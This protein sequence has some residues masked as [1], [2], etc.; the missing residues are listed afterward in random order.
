M[1]SIQRLIPLYVR[2]IFLGNRFYSNSKDLTEE[3]NRML[4][5]RLMNTKYSEKNIESNSFIK[6]ITPHYKFGP[7]RIMNYDWT[8]KSM[9]S[10][11][12]HKSVEFHKINQGYIADRVKILGSDLGAAHFVIYRGGAIR[13][14]GQEDFIRWTNK[15]EEYHTN[16]PET[17]DPN[18]FVEAIDVSD[19][20]LYYE[21]I[22]NFKNLYKLKWLSLR[23][24]PV[25]D[26]WC[27]DYI[28][29][30]IPNLEYLDIS[31][32]P[33]ITGAGIA[34]LQKLTKLKVLIVNSNNIE[35]Q[36]ACFALEDSIPGLFVSI[37][38]NETKLL[39]KEEKLNVNEIQ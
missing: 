17:Y 6:F 12:K 1:N 13:F 20:M 38:N 30:A 39:T 36:M 7:S 5:E 26:N 25:L 21:G 15:K 24:N 10:W 23:N 18:Y 19:L 32:C 4:Y 27:L 37:E 2:R 31:R 3:E 34:G 11:Y 9:F 35:V 28:S 29:Y 8:V 16:L 22:E 14:R 33:Q